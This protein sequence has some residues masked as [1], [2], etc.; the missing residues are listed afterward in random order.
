MGFSLA[1]VS[2]VRFQVDHTLWFRILSCSKVGLFRV[3]S[4]RFMLE[5][6]THVI[7]KLSFVN[8]AFV[9]RIYRARALSQPCICHRQSR[10]SDVL[11]LR[12]THWRPVPAGKK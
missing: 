5:F 3:D 6:Q 7:A 12:M 2:D 1:R 4:L 9:V 11:F 10:V 8:V